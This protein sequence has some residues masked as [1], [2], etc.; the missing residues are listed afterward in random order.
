M[1][2]L[3]ARGF[4]HHF[5]KLPVSALVRPWGIRRPCLRHYLQAFLKARVR[6]LN[7]DVKPIEFLETV[8][9]ADPGIDPAFRQKVQGG[10]L[11]GK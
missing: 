9:L 7:R 8:P 6:L 3:D 1:R 10:D 4:D 2:P 11:F 5:I